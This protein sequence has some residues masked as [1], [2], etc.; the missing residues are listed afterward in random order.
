MAS[1]W[2]S[3]DLSGTRDAVLV[4]GLATLAGCI[5]IVLAIILRP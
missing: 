5:S 2:S 1:I 4:N 3:R